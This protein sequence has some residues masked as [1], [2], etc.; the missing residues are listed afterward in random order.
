MCEMQRAEERANEMQYLKDFE[1]AGATIYELTPAESAA[2]K[3]LCKPAYD[4]W[5]GKVGQD[6][7]DAWLA[8]CPN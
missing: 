6:L 5:A 4:L 3:E 2:F 8:T 1:A 7:I